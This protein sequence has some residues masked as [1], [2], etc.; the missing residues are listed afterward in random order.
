M[1]DRPREEVS[2]RRYIRLRAEAWGFGL[3]SLC[4]I[5]GALPWYA[6]AVGAVATGVTFFTGSLLFTAAG[7]IQLLLSG[8]RPP[9]RGASTADRY[10]WWSAAVQSVGT[11]LFNVSTFAALLAAIAAPDAVGIGWRSNA[12]GSLAF[13]VSGGLALAASRR[14]HE[15]WHVRARTPQAA[16]LNMVGSVAFG[17]SAIGAYVV[18]DTTTFVS[19][20]WANLGTVLGGLCFLAAATLVRPGATATV[21]RA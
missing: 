8:R 18:P 21:A 10:D 2:P 14:R 16:W 19:L 7:L 12:W 15:L 4:F 9:H 5:A 6:E 3:G 11:V 17:L 20:L 13:L 1:D